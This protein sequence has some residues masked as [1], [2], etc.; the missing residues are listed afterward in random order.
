M[1]K[2]AM[3][4]AGFIVDFYT[5]SLHGLRSRDQVHIIYSRDEGRAKPLQKNMAFPDGPLQ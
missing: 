1:A 2:I 5:Y 4:G 3:L